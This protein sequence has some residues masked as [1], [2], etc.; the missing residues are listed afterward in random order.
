M[1]QAALIL[2]RFYQE[3]APLLART[4]RITYSATLDRVMSERLEELCNARLS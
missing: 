1:L 3:V 4:H 2:V